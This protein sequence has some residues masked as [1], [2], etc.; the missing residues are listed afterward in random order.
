M[1][2]RFSLSRDASALRAQLRRQVLF[3]T[4]FLT[5]GTSYASAQLW[6]ASGTTAISR[7]T[8]SVF[9]ADAAY[10]PIN[11]VY[12]VVMAEEDAARIN[13]R[14][15]GRFIDRVGN[16]LGAEFTIASG[17]GDLPR[18]VYGADVSNGAGGTGG[19]L[20]TWADY[21]T[22][23]ILARRVAY[24]G[25]LVGSVSTV[26][27][28]YGTSELA[29]SPTSQVF[30][31]AWTN[32]YGSHSTAV[33]RIGVNGV[34]IGAP[35]L[36]ASGDAGRSGVT[37]NSVTDVTWD[38][39]RNE[40]GILYAKAA[41]PWGMRFATMT[42]T[43]TIVADHA[44]ATIGAPPTAAALEYSPLTGNFIAV[45]ADATT[46]LITGAELS[47]AGSVIATGTLPASI[48]GGQNGLALGYNASSG[49][50]LV[51]G[52]SQVP[53]KNEQVRGLEL[54]KHGTPYSTVSE[55]TAPV[56]TANMGAPRATGRPDAAEWLVNGGNIRHY[57]QI[58]GTAS[59][60][61]GSE[62]RLD[63]CYNPDPFAALGGGTC[64]NG[65]WV[66]PA[67]A[68]PITPPASPSNGCTTADPFV[69]LGGGTCYNGGWLP[70]GMSAPSAP[71]SSPSTPS[72]PSSPVGCT[73][74]DP[75]VALGGG[76]CYNGG[77]LPPGMSAPS[78]PPSSPSTPSTP[79]SPV[80]C[81]TADPF[82]ALGGGTCYNGGW[83]PP[84]MSAPSAPPS[85][86]STPSTP[87]SPVGCTT[88][89][90]FV[91]LGG[92]TCYN[93]G[94]LPPGM[95]APSAPPSSPST[96]STP[97]SPVGCTTADPFVALGGGTCYNG[98]WL[99]PGMSAPSAPSNPAPPSTP[100]ASGTCAMPDPFVSLTSLVGQ[101]RNGGW[102][103]VPR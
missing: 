10:D 84:G 40:F 72:T 73:T 11:N 98:G 71:P 39:A 31:A 100:P 65:G 26:G 2:H 64:S 58:V 63:G 70:P 49:T 96:P 38:S 103:P 77:W 41:S 8:D 81:T 46:G 97:S 23:R 59:S 86:P 4:L 76:T 78:A 55:V 18:V 1:P 69:A 34:P 28:G 99:P 57:V 25:V 5:L 51:L 85:S 92:G 83:L 37:W 101:C 89:D 56:G 14:I 62:L 68:P 88:A 50:F 75:F 19:F 66:P 61:G 53:A 54:N 17:F 43:G 67:V 74:A 52:F 79:S 33:E 47:P 32:Y 91:A 44:V 48:L 16:P 29:Y 35:A 93:G 27:T 7:G 102:V 6:R 45:W 30:L 94:W 80:S 15:A 60:A 13:D 22:D 12:L 9:G 36:L 20:V 87:S 95:S 82:V 3:A 24:P 90:P 21:S 42:P